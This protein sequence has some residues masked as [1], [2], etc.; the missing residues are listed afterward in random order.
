MKNQNLHFA[1][2]QWYREAGRDLPWRRT[3]DAYRI[4]LSE[5][6]MQ[7]TRIE[8]GL[9]YYQRF[10]AKYPTVESLAAAEVSEVMKLWEGLG[11]YSR[12]RNMHHAAQMVVEEHQGSFPQEYQALR[13]LK[14][15]GDYTASAVAS[16]SAGESRAVL[17]GNVFRVL[18]RLY[19]ESTPINTPA[20][21]KLFSK[22]AEELLDRDDPGTHNQAM[23]ELGA[24]VCT[25]RQPK[26]NSCPWQEHCL[27][28]TRGTVAERPVKKK[29]TYD[30]QRH[31]LYIFFQTAEG[32]PVEKRAS[33]IWQ[34][35]YQFPLVESTQ[36]LEL[37][38]WRAQNPLDS[39]LPHS[40]L[41][42]REVLPA[43]KLSHQTLHIHIYTLKTSKER[44]VS[45]LGHGYQWVYGETLS[46]LA[47]P[48]PLRKWLDKKQLILPF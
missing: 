25:P 46:Q 24:T 30:R 45:A 14:G 12:A 44:V 3:Q 26:C 5:V 22:L 39:L 15:V 20:G 47:F 23:M 40:E 6:I 32:I 7:Q 38:Q 28:R 10:V 13:S 4:W 21:Q 9:P 2:R 1:L 29:K 18:S 41:L 36:A 43:H 11:Y 8:Q 17:D 31:L 19:D 33:G 27:A 35:L 34:G 37:D 42:L 48:R 16:F